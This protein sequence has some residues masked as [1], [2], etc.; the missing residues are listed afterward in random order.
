MFADK[1]KGF[2]FCVDAKAVYVI[3]TPLWKI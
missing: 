2:W 1:S 3:C